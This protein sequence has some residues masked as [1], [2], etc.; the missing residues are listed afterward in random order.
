MIMQR[1]GECDGTCANEIIF[2]AFPQLEGRCA[3]SG[4]SGRCTLAPCDALRL[5][6]PV[7][8]TDQTIG[9]PAIEPKLLPTESVPQAT[10]GQE[11]SPLFPRTTYTRSRSHTHPYHPRDGQH[12]YRERQ[13]TAETTQLPINGSTCTP[14]LPSPYPTVTHQHST[15]VLV[16][17]H[18]RSSPSCLTHTSPSNYHGLHRCKRTNTID[19]AQREKEE[20]RDL[21][22]ASEIITLWGERDESVSVICLSFASSTFHYG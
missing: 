10:G 3:P 20:M 21:T 9:G 7:A 18:P 17:H 16:N 19:F 14:P 8:P 1:D 2:G 5:E 6:D 22:R 13:P 11:E 15:S 4:C 12:S